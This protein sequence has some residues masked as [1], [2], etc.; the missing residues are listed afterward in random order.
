MFGE[1]TLRTIVRELIDKLRKNISTDWMIREN[2]RA[3]LRVLVKRILRAHGYPLEKLKEATQTVLEQ[4]ELL[5]D[6]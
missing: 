6:E 3:N 2:V 1:E 4:T 5:S